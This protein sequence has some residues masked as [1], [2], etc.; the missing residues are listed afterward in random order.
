MS[1]YLISIAWIL[2]LG[3]SVA[4]IKNNEYQNQILGFGLIFYLVG[5][6]LA[7]FEDEDK[8]TMEG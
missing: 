7:Q 2:F 8:G 4:L 6:L 5:T 1:K 3:Y